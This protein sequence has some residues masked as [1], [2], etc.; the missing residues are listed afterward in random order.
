MP[1][2]VGFAAMSAAKF[3]PWAMLARLRAERIS[4]PSPIS[5]FSSFSRGGA[6]GFNAPAGTDDHILK[7]SAGQ[8]YNY[9]W[10]P[11]EQDTQY[12]RGL[13]ARRRKA[14]SDGRASLVPPH[15]IAALKAAGLPTGEDEG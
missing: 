11:L 10:L 9:A 6:S 2:G 4:A 7:L 13:A 5:N 14:M 1:R 12:L 8:Q 15:V 3:D